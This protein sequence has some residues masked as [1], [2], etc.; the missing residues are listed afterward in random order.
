MQAAAPSWGRAFSWGTGAFGLSL[1]LAMP[2]WFAM[3]AQASRSQIVD[4]AD[5]LGSLLLAP[6]IETAFLVWALGRRE[7][8]AAPWEVV[9]IAALL[10][11]AHLPFRPHWLF[12]LPVMSAFLVFAGYLR[13][14][15]ATASACVCW[16][17]GSVMHGW[18]NTLALAVV[19]LS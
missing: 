7:R 5:V 14:R 15:R 19:A 17:E 8:V 18:H 3:R 9:L 1:V 11:A 6:A 10:A 2:A 13:W 12:F 4:A 16:L